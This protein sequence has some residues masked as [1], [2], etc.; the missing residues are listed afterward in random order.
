MEA[1]SRDLPFDFFGALTELVSATNR[2][3]QFKIANAIL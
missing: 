3:R 1:R 2:H